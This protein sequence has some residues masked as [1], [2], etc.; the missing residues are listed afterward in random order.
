MKWLT[1]NL[2]KMNSRIQGDD[3]N[4]LIELYG[5]SAEQQVLQDT[6]R[7][8]EEL[9][10]FGDGTMPADIVNASLMLADFAYQQRSP[11]DKMKWYAVPYTY[12]KIIKPYVR[13]AYERED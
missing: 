13:L 2:I 4:E 10:Q 3:E 6:G 5:N 1:L 7:T 11:V 9:L 12:E 8:Y